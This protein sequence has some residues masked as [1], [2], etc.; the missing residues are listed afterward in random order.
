MRGIS[1]VE[2]ILLLAIVECGFEYLEHEVKALFGFSKANRIEIP[3]PSFVSIYVRCISLQLKL[4][5]LLV[6]QRER[7]KFFEGLKTH[8]SNT[9]LEYPDKENRKRRKLE[10]LPKA[11]PDPPRILTKSELKAQED[12]D[13]RLKNYLK[14]KLSGLMDLLKNR[15]KRF[16]KPPIVSFLYLICV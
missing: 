2:Q 5:T 4:L 15:Y 6:G 10:I 8:I 13:K 16:R 12:K 7:Y 1:P 11:P 9:P 14:I 3:K